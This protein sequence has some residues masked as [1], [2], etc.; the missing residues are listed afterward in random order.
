VRWKGYL[1]VTVLLVSIALAAFGTGCGGK[2]TPKPGSTGAGETTAPG[3]ADATPVGSEVAVVRGEYGDLPADVRAWVDAAVS[4]PAGQVR[5][6]GDRTYI[7]LTMGRKLTGGYVAEIV[8]VTRREGSLETLVRLTEPK[9]GEMTTQVENFPYDLVAVAATAL[10][11]EFTVEGDPEHYIM[12][13]I[14]TDGMQPV[15]AETEWI[16]IFAPAPGAEVAG[17]F[18]LSGVASTFEGTVNFRVL[19]PTGKKLSESY[20]T[21]CMGDW[22]YFQ[23]NVPVPREATTGGGQLT[24]EVFTYSAKDGSEQDKMTIPLTVVGGS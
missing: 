18:V 2:Q 14:N 16:K 19:G 4:I 7:L 20:A 6:F 3:N 24:L 8:S 5:T 17:T 21:A 15:V 10:A 11:V 12:R 9:E 23:V 22:G 13:V 1:L